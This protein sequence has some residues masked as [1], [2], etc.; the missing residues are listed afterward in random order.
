MLEML[1]IA[2]K[3]AKLSDE[4]LQAFSTAFRIM[5]GENMDCY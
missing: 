1:F 5:L 2:T 3:K 4:C